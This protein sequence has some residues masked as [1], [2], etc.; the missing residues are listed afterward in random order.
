[1][2]TTRTLQC[3]SMHNCEHYHSFS[4]LYPQFEYII[5]VVTDQADTI[6]T[7]PFYFKR[8][9]LF[10]HRSNSKKMTCQLLCPMQFYSE[11]G[12]FKNSH[13]WTT[14]TQTLCIHAA[15]AM[16]VYLS[17]PSSCLNGSSSACVLLQLLTNEQIINQRD[18]QTNKQKTQII[19]VRMTLLLLYWWKHKTRHRIDQ[20]TTFW[21]HRNWLIEYLL[22][23][24]RNCI[25]SDM[26][27]STF[28]ET[29][30]ICIV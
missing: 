15:R 10:F 3:R 30:K 18:K 14:I 7:F 6:Y 25:V 29:D 1:M 16:T 19:V 17:L 11:H 22:Y 8:R 12:K 27:N 28:L 21:L 9:K 4:V 23:C 26:I 13:A 2:K 5:F 24:D 20:Y